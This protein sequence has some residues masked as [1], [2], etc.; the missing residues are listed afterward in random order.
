MSIENALLS[1]VVYDRV[2]YESAK[3]YVEEDTLSTVGRA[4]Y[5]T[6]E[7]YYQLDP[8]ARSTDTAILLERLERK[9]PK[10]TEVFR[11]LVLGLDPATGGRNVAREVID[12]RRRSAGN[13]LMQAIGA[14][15]PPM[16]ITPLLDTYREANNA[17]QLLDAG[18][19]TMFETG[20]SA[21][22]QYTEDDANR[23][24]LLPLSL[25]K[26]I[27]GGILPGHTV[28]VFGR[29]NVGKSA[30]AINMT[31]GFLRQGKRVLFVENEDLLE[32]TANRVG[33]R[34]TGLDRDRAIQIPTEYEKLAI[35]RGYNNFLLPDPAPPYVAD[36]DRLLGQIKPD[37]CVV[38]QARNLTS[39]TRDV[40]AQ[41]DNIAKGL[42]NIGKRRRIGMVLVTAAREGESDYSGDMKDKSILEQ[43]DVYS[44]K[45]GF[46][47][48]AD[49][50]IGVGSNHALEDQGML[51]L[52]I[53]K[54]K[55]GKYN[56]KTK[57]VIY[58]TADFDRGLLRD[59]AK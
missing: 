50:M 48:V 41:L 55:L 54:N 43:H 40:V 22:I 47:A 8:R 42:R 13:A 2:A 37:V 5:D 56:G 14:D 46:P 10:R 12:L 58:V 6:V 34:L 9:Y 20:L 19:G 24:K 26:Y 53:C 7:E 11:E 44:S 49:L 4:L 35:E 51:A 16:D 57:G 29:V 38:N 31:A 27:R 3:E 1:A 45:T 39:G 18:G 36:I 15:R 17:T 23:I 59:E 32:D 28:I 21:L 25:N 30:V 33:L 52:S